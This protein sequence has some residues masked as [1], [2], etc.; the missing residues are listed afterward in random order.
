MT[1]WRQHALTIKPLEDLGLLVPFS[2]HG[3]PNRGSKT[4]AKF[5]KTFCI[6]STGSSDDLANI[7][8]LM[9]WLQSDVRGSSTQYVALRGDK[10]TSKW[11]TG[12]VR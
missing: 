4:T 6:A 5:C 1:E 7:T 10:S 11:T 3:T 2:A 12:E 8:K 9:V